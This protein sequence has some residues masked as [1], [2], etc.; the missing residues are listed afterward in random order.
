MANIP[1]TPPFCSEAH[2][3]AAPDGLMDPRT[4]AAFLG[5]SVLSLADWRCK[6]TGPTYIKLGSAVRYRRSDL[7]AWLDSRT[8]KGASA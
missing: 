3:L 8:R 2:H 4:T 1:Q 7:D 6:G 5:L